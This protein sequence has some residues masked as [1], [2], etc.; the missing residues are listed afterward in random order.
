MWEHRKSKNLMDKLKIDVKINVCT[1]KKNRINAWIFCLAD[2]FLMFYVNY[3]PF[4]A[5]N[6]KKM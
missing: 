1:H 4:G 2:V 3:V 5:G 6:R